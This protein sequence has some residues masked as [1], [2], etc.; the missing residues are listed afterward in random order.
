MKR[1]DTLPALLGIAASSVSLCG[2]AQQPAKVARIGFL[3]ATSHSGY[4]E[5]IE[6][7]QAGLRD[8]GYIAGKNIAIEFRWAEGKYDRLPELAAELVR[9]KVDIIV[10][11][12]TP[13]TRA[14]KQAS[15]A[16]PV[17]M[18]TCGD[19]VASGIVASLA[20]PGGNVT[21]NTFSAPNSL[22]SGLSYSRKHYRESPVSEF[23]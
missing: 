23:Y 1:R 12:G 2:W 8:L 9:L 15:T 22:P 6:A 5:R 4:E 14:A 3:G 13:G 17:V 18:A 10:T 21:G 16:I 11:H 20:R 7:L 19:A